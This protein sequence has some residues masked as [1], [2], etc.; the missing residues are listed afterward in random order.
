MARI[1]GQDPSNSDITHALLARTGVI[2][3]LR[4]LIEKEKQ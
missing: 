3:L 4:E 2:D 1:P